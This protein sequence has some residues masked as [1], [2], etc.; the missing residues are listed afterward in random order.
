MLLKDKMGL[1]L[2]NFN[3]LGV[4]WK[5]WLLGRGILRKTDIEGGIA[6]K[7]GLGQ[8]GDLRGLDKKDGGGIFLEGRL[9]PQCTL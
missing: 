1:R 5:I 2:K 6:K 3:S 4:D 7:G 9:I 8:F